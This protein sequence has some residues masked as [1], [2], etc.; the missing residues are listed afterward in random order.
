MSNQRESQFKSGGRERFVTR[1]PRW[2]PQG[3]SHMT[4][5]VNCPCVNIYE[6]SI[7]MQS[8][9]KYIFFNANQFKRIF[10]LNKFKCYQSEIR[11]STLYVN[12]QLSREYIRP[13]PKQFDLG[14]RLRMQLCS[15]SA[16][17]DGQI[18][19]D[20][21]FSSGSKRHPPLPLF[22]V[23]LQKQPSCFILHF[24]FTWVESESF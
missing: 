3:S 7:L 15:S 16:S 11:H 1:E 17:L 18:S 21:V 20:H 2:A 22:K 9:S 14:Q 13:Q 6:C 4:I 10:C 8:N 12:W 24:F 23:I 19:E 5:Y